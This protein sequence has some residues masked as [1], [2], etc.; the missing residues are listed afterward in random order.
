MRVFLIDDEI[1]YSK[2]LKPV[3]K[4]AGHVLGYANSGETAFKNIASFNPDVIVLDIRLPDMSGF[5]IFSRL[6]NDEHF[7]NIPVIFVTSYNELES[8]L[9]AF[10]LGAEDY[11]SK[12]FIP[13]ELLARLEILARRREYLK[14]AETNVRVK[15]N[16]SNVIAIHSL[17]GGVGCT[18]LAINLALAHFQLWQKPTLVIDS[19]L[20]SGQVALFLNTSPKSTWREFSDKGPDDIDYYMIN[21]LVNLHKSGIRY[22]ASPSLPVPFE[23]LN[24]IYPMTIEELRGQYDMVVIDTP[25]DFTDISV[26]SLDAA[27]RILLL[28]APEIGSLRAAICA[29]KTYDNLGYSP[30]KISIV[31]NSVNQLTTLKEK[32]IEKS[33]SHRIDFQLP[34][35]ASVVKAINSGEPFLVTDSTLPISSRIEDLAY[36]I[37]RDELKI[38]PPASP[39][40]TW[41]N[42]TKRINEGKI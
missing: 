12:P 27:D 36:T 23:K 3:L 28:I 26:M 1:V 6:H 19:V 8:K 41:K 9:K 4:K 31:L 35:S 39:T 24:D 34:F 32:Q 20:V 40:S 5:D 33:L 25:H 17:R 42:V 18:S 14:L 29:L 7:S 30:D 16:S 10:E 13:E 15:Q 22:I 37:S 21:N 11:L 38:I 2:M